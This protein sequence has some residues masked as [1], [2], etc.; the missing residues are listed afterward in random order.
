MRGFLIFIAVLVYLFSVIYIESEFI[1]LELRKENLESLLT[2]LKNQ[3]KLLEFEVMNLSNLATIK[4]QAHAR[5]FIFPE[6]EDILG[7]VK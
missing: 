5:G 4:A 7:V 3:R 6:E 1:K 2:E